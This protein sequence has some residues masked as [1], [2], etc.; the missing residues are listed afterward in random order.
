[1]SNASTCCVI[2]GLVLRFR[3]DVDVDAKLAK[4]RS[5]HFLWASDLDKVLLLQKICKSDYLP[6]ID[7][8]FAAVW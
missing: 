8:E 4:P 5:W 2:L 6:R 7:T 3:R 1:M